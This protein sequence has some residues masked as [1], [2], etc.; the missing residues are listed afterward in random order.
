MPVTSLPI[1]SQITGDKYA[2]LQEKLYRY[3]G[4]YTQTRTLRK[5][6]VNHSADVFGYIFS[7]VSPEQI[8]KNPYYA[9]GDYVGMSGLERT[10]EEHLRGTKGKQIVLVDNKNRKQR[11]FLPTENTTKKRSSGKTCIPL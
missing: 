10:Y 9:P 5:Y 1:D 4:F 6:N 11:V 2:I 3:P 7:E 8:K